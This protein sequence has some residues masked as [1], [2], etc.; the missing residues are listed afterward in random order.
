M[1][2]Q[3]PL[4]YLITGEP[5][6]DQL[7][8]HLMRALRE[9]TGGNVSFAGVGG[10]RM[11]S[12]GIDSLFPMSEMSFMGVDFL[13]HLRSILR[14]IGETV[15]DIERQKPAAL[16][17][18]DAQGFSKQVGKRLRAR[19][20]IPIIHY[21][22]PTVWAYRP[23]RARKV[24]RYLD[25]L[26]AIFPFEPPMFERHGLETTFVGHP[27]AEAASE[28]PNRDEARRLLGI[29]PDSTV[30]C[31]LPGSRKAELARI[32]S[33]FQMVITRLAGEVEALHCLV[34]TVT[35][36]ADQVSELTAGWPCPVTV[37]REPQ[38]KYQA[39]AAADVA[40][41]TSGTVAVET[42][43]ASLPTVVV[44]KTVPLGFAFIRTLR[45]LKTKYVSGANLVLGREAMPE[46]LQNRAE[47]EAVS[48][49]LIHLLQDKGAQETMRADLEETRRLFQVGGE[50][51]SM[52]A[53]RAILDEI[54]R[55]PHGRR[56][57]NQTANQPGS[58]P[59][60]K[61]E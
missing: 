46:F 22:A 15:D 39:F 33:L 38:Q 24:A 17:T 2:T 54:D 27:A 13:P 60:T 12:E 7:G 58:E 37:L 28:Q 52:V 56:A 40:L 14:R 32:A 53:A 19:L 25:R 4:I 47:P 11:T 3:Q 26:L 45:I 16:I 48:A 23:G 41:A 49:A 42:A 61:K 1:T 9:A 18:I 59:G 31:A 35:D 29:R 8:A 36:V 10:E 55:F 34:P 51:P 5:S 43:F 30:I 6:G 21:V 57:A 50:R 44:Y 20:D